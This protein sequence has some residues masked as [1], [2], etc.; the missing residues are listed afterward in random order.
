MAG[1]CHCVSESMDRGLVVV[2][3]REDGS[4]DM[5]DLESK[6]QEHG[7]RLCGIMITNP[8]TRGLFEPHFKEIARKVREAGALVY[9]DGANMNAIAGWVDLKKL[10]VD[11]AHQNLHKT[12]SIP[13]GGGGPGDAV[14]AVDEKLAAYLP[15][16]Q[17]VRKNGIYQTIKCSK[18]IGTFHRHFGNFA[19]KVRAL[20]YVLRLGKEGMP[21]MSALAVLSANYVLEKVKDSYALLP[22]GNLPRMHEF[23]LTLKAPYFKKLEKVGLSKAA[24]MPALGKLFL[25]FGFHAPTIAWP[26]PLGMMIEPTESFTQAQ[27]DRFADTLLTMLSLI[28][29]CPE[30][31]LKAPRTT[32]VDKVDE[33]DANRQLCLSEPLKDVP[34]PHPHRLHP[35]QLLEMPLNKLMATFAEVPASLA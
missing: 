33:V 18:S 19:H 28:E 3:E 22:E 11:A 20:T 34:V 4:I 27:L 31:L 9:L 30:V 21:K 1:L 24:A 15:G 8:N 17:V 23:I 7:P 16:I 10:G 29:K 35:R 25:D 12:W 13:H 14:V 2:A 5:E 26:E 32:P 6:I